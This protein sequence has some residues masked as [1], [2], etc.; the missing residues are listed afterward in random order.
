MP[1]FFQKLPN[2]S[3]NVLS[4]YKTYKVYPSILQPSFE[5]PIFEILPILR[6]QIDIQ[7]KPLNIITLRALIFVYITQL[8]F[9]IVI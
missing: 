1:D 7:W 5:L 3:K 9:V 8:I 2:F 6:R 4:G